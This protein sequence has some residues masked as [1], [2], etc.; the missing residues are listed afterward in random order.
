VSP[1]E[2]SKVPGRVVSQ[3]P[4]APEFAVGAVLSGLFV[5]GALKDIFWDIRGSPPAISV[6]AAVFFGAAMVINLLALAHVR[7]T[8]READTK[9]L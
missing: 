9:K 8:S 6:L 2:S 4:D 1:C 7:R 3:V 5:V